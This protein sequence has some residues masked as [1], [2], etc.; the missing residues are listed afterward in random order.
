MDERV[1]ILLVDDEP[2][3]LQSLKR[4]FRSE[5]YEVITAESWTKGLDQFAM[6]VPVRV[7]ISD[8]RMPVMNGVD[9]LKA[10]YERSPETVR[11]ILSGYADKPVL[12]EAVQSGRIYKYLA[13]PWDDDFLKSTVRKGIKQTASA[14]DKRER[15]QALLEENI[16]LHSS[17]DA[18]TERVTDRADFVQRMNRVMTNSQKVLD[19]MG[20]G[21][22]C[23]GSD[24]VILLCNDAAAAWLKTTPQ[25]LI[26]NA[27]H[28][29]LSRGLTGFIR[30]LLS[31]VKVGSHYY[32]EEGMNLR[33]IQL[34]HNDSDVSALIF[35]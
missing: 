11:I 1:V 3:I 14:W 10:V 26:G 17:N 32:V 12:L 25:R 19:A 9:F 23:I 7:V 20:P 18:L 29:V 6:G 15:I 35:I 21:I 22:L 28:E 8:Y 13:K 24:G 27:A 2:S 34:R 30:E 5:P 33:G 16:L 4:V 31:S